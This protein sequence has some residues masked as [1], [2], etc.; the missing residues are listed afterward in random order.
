MKKSDLKNTP[1]IPGVNLWAFALYFNRYLQCQQGS[2][3]GTNSSNLPMHKKLKLT[4]HSR[5]DEPFVSPDPHWEVWRTESCNYSVLQTR[6]HIVQHWMLQKLHWS[7]KCGLARW[8]PFWETVPPE[9]SCLLLG[10]LATA[11]KSRSTP[12]TAL[13]CKAPSAPTD[14]DEGSWPIHK[15]TVFFYFGSI[16]KIS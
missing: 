15:K 13:N 10:H 8:E 3:T 16:L 12:D 4:W 11:A 7:Y 14:V 6:P 2:C 9:S 5:Y 1:K